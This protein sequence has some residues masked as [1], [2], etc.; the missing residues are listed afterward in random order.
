M[1]YSTSRMEFLVAMPISMTRPISDGIE[2]ALPLANVIRQRKPEQN[3]EII[4]KN[5]NTKEIYNSNLYFIYADAGRHE[6]H[7]YYG[8]FI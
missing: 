2:K 8:R 6:W 1:A 3:T 4:V 7:N 5:E